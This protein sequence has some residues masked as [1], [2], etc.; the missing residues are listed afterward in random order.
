VSLSEV[1]ARNNE[2]GLQVLANDNSTIADLSTDTVGFE[3]ENDAAAFEANDGATIEDLEF[4]TTGFN[5]SGGT[6]LALIADGGNV[7]DVSLDTVIASNNTVGLNVSATDDGTV[8]DLNAS[9]ALLGDGDVGADISAGQPGAGDAASVT[10]VSFETA[11]LNGTSGTGLRVQSWSGSRVDNLSVDTAFLSDNDVGLMAASYNSSTIADLTLF[12]AIVKDNRIGSMITPRD[13]STIEDVNVST[14]LH[15]SN[16]EAG[17]LLRAGE[18]GGSGSAVLSDVNVTPNAFN[19]TASGP[20]VSVTAGGNGTVRDVRVFRNLI[21]DNDEGVRLGAEGTAQLRSIS[22]RQVAIENN[23]NG[24]ALNGTGSHSGV[25]VKESLIRD[26]DVGIFAS[27]T[28]DTAGMSIHFSALINNTLG[29]DNDADTVFDARTVWWGDSSGPSTAPT[30]GVSPVED[31]VGGQL[32]DGDGDTVSED[33]TDAGV[34]NVRFIPAIGAKDPAGDD[35]QLIDPVP[36][37]TTPRQEFNGFE[38]NGTA[39]RFEIEDQEIAGFTVEGETFTGEVGDF[40]GLALWER[41]IFPLRAS[42]DDA[43]NRVQNPPTFLD[44]SEGD[45][46]INR[47]YLKVFQQDNSITVEFSEAAGTNTTRFANKEVQLHAV[48]ANET[49]DLEGTFNRS[50][51]TDNGDVTFGTDVVQWVDIQNKTLDSDGEL[52]GS[53]AFEFTPSKPGEYLLILTTVESGDGFRLN[54]TTGQVTLN[55]LNDSTIVAGTDVISV[56]QTDSEAKPNES[57][58]EAGKALTFDARSNLADRDVHHAI[59]LYDNAS[60]EDRLVRINTSIETSGSDVI[61]ET[62]GTT[63]PGGGQPFL[64]SVDAS[65]DGT[66]NNITVSESVDSVASNE[67]ILLNGDSRQNV[68]VSVPPNASIPFDGEETKTFQWVHLAVA[69]D[70][71]TNRSTDVGSVTVTKPDA[72]FPEIDVSP[73]SLSFGSINVSETATD[74]VDVTNI[75]NATLNITSTSIVGDDPD[76]FD[77]LGNVPSSIDPG[78]ST[79]ITVEFDPERPLEDKSAQLEIGSNDSDRDPTI[80]TLDGTATEADTDDDDDDDDDDEDGVIPSPPPEEPEPVNVTILQSG[81]DEFVI[82]VTNVRGGATL[83]ISTLGLGDEDVRFDGVI[84]QLNDSVETDSFT[85]TLRQSRTVSE[86]TPPLDIVGSVPRYLNVTTD[87]ISDDDIDNV[88]FR[89]RISERVLGDRPTE[90]VGFYRFSEPPWSL[91]DTEF[92]R[93]TSAGLFRFGADSPGFSEFAIGI[94]EPR[95]EIINTSLDPERVNVGERAAASVTIENTGDAG[96]EFTAALNVNGEVTRTTTV[97]IPAGESRTRIFGVSFQEPGEYDLAVNGTAVGT[98]VVT[99]E[100]P[101]PTPTTPTPTPTTPTPTTPTATATPTTPTA[102]ATPTTDTPTEP[103][104][105]PVALIAVIVLLLVI[106]AFLAYYFGSESGPGGSGGSD[107]SGGSGDGD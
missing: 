36:R 9:T 88:R 71:A 98:L 91:L 49:T 13:D 50:I 61:F 80:V 73:T 100:T 62:S 11:G 22:V 66:V 40:V 67:V 83:N 10:N 47:Q 76:E 86:G 17:L 18:S 92:V 54:D 37:T 32:A 48:R 51:D 75:G 39:F 24:V 43:A 8:A 12:Q 82:R 46:S 30:A 2:D 102:T 29:V 33:P 89:F 72:K 101:T 31:P 7:T 4:V 35:P 44:T 3:S 45:V 93:R 85:I 97:S 77:V 21:V 42:A 52:E 96:G 34:S 64:L 59:V 87:G 74:T 27:P 60:Y 99:E 57:R 19:E 65:T 104:G 105:P 15:S 81:P 1:D 23:T 95:F 53:D 16:D 107:G 70:N 6:G 84:V 90:N 106:A 20:G 14:T 38:L 69:T 103:D 55:A 63:A 58:V 79:T 28:T 25:R 41:A 56:Q 26:N 78:D 94:A 5:E 68:T